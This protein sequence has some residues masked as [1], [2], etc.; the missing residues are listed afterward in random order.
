MKLI[1]PEV[2]DIT[3]TDF[4]LKGIHKQIELAARTCYKSE[5]KITEDSAEPFVKM[6]EDR[7]HTAMLEHGTVYL[8]VTDNTHVYE[9]DKLFYN[10]HSCTVLGEDKYIYITTNLRVINELGL[11]DKLL[12]AR[13]LEYDEAMHIPRYSFR[14]IC[15]IGVARELCR[16]RVF[17]FAQEST[18]YCNYTKEKF[19][20]VS[21]IEPYWY[22]DAR[23]VMQSYFKNSLDTASETYFTMIEN[24]FTAQ[25]AREVLPLATKTEIVMTG[26]LPQWKQFLNLRLSNAAHPD[27]RIIAGQIKELIGKNH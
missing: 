22:A 19:G 15:S 6:L 3:Q 13:Y 1:Q 4:S 20:G 21:F 17:S 23:P 24:N 27:M 8:K 18:R 26:T 16:H 7:G 12:K 5:D 10:A 9:T 2:I 11:K 25:Q 14:I